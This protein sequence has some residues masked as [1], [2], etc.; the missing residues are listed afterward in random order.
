MG[1][2]FKEG[3]WL[4]TELRECRVPGNL[5]ELRQPPSKGHYY[6]RDTDFQRSH[7]SHETQSDG[8]VRKALAG[9][10]RLAEGKEYCLLQEFCSDMASGSL[11]QKKSV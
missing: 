2:V 9:T 6:Q 10:E 4:S 7:N 8:C 5:G 1:K 3:G 11:I